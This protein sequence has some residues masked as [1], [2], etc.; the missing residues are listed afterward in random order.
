MSTVTHRKFIT[1]C[2][3]F[4]T[5]L[6]TFRL[7]D[8]NRALRCFENALVRNPKNSDARA[9]VGMIYQLQGKTARAITEYLEALNNTDSVELIND[10][11]ETSLKSHAQVNYADTRVLALNEGNE[12]I[13]AGNLFR[14]TK[15]EVDKELSEAEWVERKE[16][17]LE[18]RIAASNEFFS[19]GTEELRPNMSREWL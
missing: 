17:D 9:T 13:E 6:F 16:S 1:V 2:F 7:Q 14:D 3:S 12:I 4:L 11:L 15:D 19:D 18:Q 10:L 5:H 8:Y